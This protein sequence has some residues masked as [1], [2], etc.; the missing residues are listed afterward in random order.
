MHPKELP[1]FP[2][3]KDGSGGKATDFDGKVKALRSVLFP[4]VPNADLADVTETS[5][6]EPIQM[7]GIITYKEVKE[8]I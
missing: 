3:I 1:Q 2:A 4:P 6:P 7:E 8:A 5:Y